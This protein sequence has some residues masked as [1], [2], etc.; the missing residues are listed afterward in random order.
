MK[1]LRLIAIC[2]C[3]VLVPVARSQDEPTLKHLTVV[4]AQSGPNASMAALSI[5]RVGEPSHSV[6]HLRGNVEIRIPFC[7]SQGAPRPVCNGYLVI[8][9]DQADFHE[10]TGEIDSIANATV[11]RLSETIRR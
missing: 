10:D 3:G 4:T 7:V 5:V 2:A 1:T 8:R 9:A 6:I 11:T